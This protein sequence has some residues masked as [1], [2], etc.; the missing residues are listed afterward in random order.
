MA[1][2]NPLDEFKPESGLLIEVEPA[3]AF[4]SAWRLKYDEVAAHG[5]PAHISVLYPFVA[6]GLIDDA[7]L[8]KAR[9]TIA[10]FSCFDFTLTT[11]EQFPGVVWLNPEPDQAF[12][13]ITAALWDAFPQCP[14]YEN[15]H[16]DP[17]PHLT[18]AQVEDPV[19]QAT[20]HTSI[21]ADLDGHLPIACRATAVTLFVTT[22]PD[23]WSRPERFNLA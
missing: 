17:Q 8:D 14:P 15:R 9:S 23:T 22:E 13:A 18:I 20:M 1:D 16:P 12:R 10:G 4:V 11:V 7:V 3:D 5:I 19:D 6:P 2:P 21:E